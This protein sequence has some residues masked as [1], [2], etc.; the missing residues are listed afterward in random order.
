MSNLKVFVD[1]EDSRWTAAIAD[2]AAVVDKVKDEVVKRVA[3][4]VDFLRDDK[5]FSVN[6]C[7]SDDEAVHKLNKEFRNMDKPTNVLSFAN[8]DDEMFDEILASEDEIEL[9]DIIIAFDT[10]QREALE[11]GISFYDHF[12]HLW[13]HGLLHILGYDHM[14]PEDAAEMEQREI[15]ILAELN[16]DNPYRDEE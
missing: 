3:G 14:E 15:E 16:I 10:M 12:C 5:S 6:L 7:L 4:E 9:G 2:I 13:A 8:I 11:Q 1:V